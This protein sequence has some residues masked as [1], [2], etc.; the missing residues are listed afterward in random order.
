MTDRFSPFGPSGGRARPAA[1]GQRAANRFP[2]HFGS[3]AATEKDP[4]GL[5]YSAIAY[6]DKEW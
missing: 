6:V 2:D 1:A 5:Q 4:V 3:F